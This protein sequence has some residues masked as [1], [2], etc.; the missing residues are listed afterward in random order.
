MATDRSGRKSRGIRQVLEQRE[1]QLLALH[2]AA[3]ALTEDLDLQSVLQRVA[4]LSREVVGTRYA[5]LGVL[6]DS[7]QRLGDFITAGIEPEVRR[8]ISHLPTGEGL[9]GYLIK[10][11]RPLRVEHIADHPD[12][13]GFCANHPKMD[14]LLGVP[15]SSKG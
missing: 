5:G 2:E 13:A 4:E 6:D 11:G 7:G 9:L 8:N 14:S 15:V 10:D 12:S 1:R 3:V